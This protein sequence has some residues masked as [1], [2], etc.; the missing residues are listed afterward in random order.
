MKN[1]VKFAGWVVGVVIV[2]LDLVAYLGM[3]WTPDLSNPRDKW[4]LFCISIATFAACFAAGWYQRGQKDMDE[5][6]PLNDQLAGKQAAL[7]NERRKNVELAKTIQDMLDAEQAQRDEDADRILKLTMAEYDVID[8]ILMANADGKQYRSRYSEAIGHLYSSGVI[9]SLND[10]N[11]YVINMKLRPFFEK[12][13]DAIHE[14]AN[15]TND[16]RRRIAQLVR[17]GEYPQNNPS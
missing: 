12:Y 9:E 11:T 13:E 7:D 17:D 4:V 8:G 1:I 2:V 3:P 15:G 10:G 5:I 14:I 16:D 6:Q